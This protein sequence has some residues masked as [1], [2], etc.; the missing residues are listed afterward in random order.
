[1]M[2]GSVWQHNAQSATAILRCPDDVIR[3][4]ARL[5]GVSQAL[6]RDVISHAP[7]VAQISLLPSARSVQPEHGIYTQ[8]AIQF[9][10]PIQST[11]APYWPH[12]LAQSAPA[13]HNC[14]RTTLS[15]LS[16]KYRT[17]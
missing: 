17:L 7:K 8:L 10:R 9:V 6:P 12:S 3:L 4:L 5:D 1:M 14:P 15:R 11:H 2:C 13:T 16:A